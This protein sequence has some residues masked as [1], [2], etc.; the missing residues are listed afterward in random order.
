MP[1]SRAHPHLLRITSFLLFLTNVHNSK[2]RGPFYRT[3]FCRISTLIKKSYCI[4]GILCSKKNSESICICIFAFLFTIILMWTSNSW[5][6]QFAHDRW[7]NHYGL[8]WCFQVPWK[9]TANRRDDG[10][11][12]LGKLIF[13]LYI[14]LLLHWMKGL[15]FSGFLKYYCLVSLFF[16]SGILPWQ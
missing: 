5:P 15:S 10:S 4:N 2:N 11:L 16:L 1:W 12:E 3:K 13:S 9:V 8:F 7:T 14:F 6:G